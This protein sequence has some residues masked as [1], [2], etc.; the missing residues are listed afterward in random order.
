[1]LTFQNKKVFFVVS[2]LW[3]QKEQRLSSRGFQGLTLIKPALHCKLIV[4]L[5]L[6]PLGR[7]SY[8]ILAKFLGVSG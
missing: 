2:G 3:K 4:D 1:M 6:R 8:I 7:R 5:S